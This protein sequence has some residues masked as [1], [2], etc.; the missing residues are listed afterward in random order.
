MAEKVPL[1]KDPAIMDSFGVHPENVCHSEIT[2][3]SEP[4]DPYAR[5]TCPIGMHDSP[6]PWASTV[7]NRPK[8]S[9]NM[10]Y[11]REGQIGPENSTLII[12]AS[13]AKQHE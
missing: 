9:S 1:G 5:P 2:I 6:S 4:G 8:H 12:E 10:G 7:S 11:P 3:T 13:K